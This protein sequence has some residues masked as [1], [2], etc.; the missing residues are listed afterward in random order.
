MRVVFVFKDHFKSGEFNDG[1]GKGR[2]LRPHAVP[3]ILSKNK[4]ILSAP[5]IEED[6]TTG[7]AHYGPGVV[8]GLD[9][10]DTDDLIVED[11]GMSDSNESPG[12]SVDPGRSNVGLLSGAFCMFI[13]VLG[14]VAQA[15]TIVYGAVSR[16]H[17]AYSEDIAKLKSTIVE[18]QFQLYNRKNHNKVLRHRYLNCLAKY[19]AIKSRLKVVSE[20]PT[21]LA[22]R[23]L[24]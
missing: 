3:V 5:F 8:I 11:I 10:M 20:P 16:E 7:T 2:R 23:K 21:N 4:V 18:L 9:A 13:F 22:L 17:R 14:L 12:V 15:W 19:K 1:T 6:M 24:A